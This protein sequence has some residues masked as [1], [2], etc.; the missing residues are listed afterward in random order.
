MREEV[1]LPTILCICLPRSLSHLLASSHGNWYY[2]WKTQIARP[3]CMHV[4]ISR[5][6]GAHVLCCHWTIQNTLTN[7]RWRDKVSDPCKTTREEKD[8]FPYR[9]INKTLDWI[10]YLSTSLKCAIHFIISNYFLLTSYETLN[11]K[12]QNAGVNTGSYYFYYFYVRNN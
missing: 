12:I 3:F 10:N 11:S 9:L 1:L 7:H 2:R 4:Y 5:R 6:N 8:L